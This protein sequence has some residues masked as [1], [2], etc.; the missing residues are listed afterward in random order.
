MSRSSPSRK[1]GGFTLVE[2]LVVIAIVAALIALLLPAV[3]NAREAARR[4]DCQNNLKQLA[5]AAH[6]FESAYGNFPTVGRS[7]VYVG[8]RPTGG[9]NLWV[10]LLPYFE[11]NNLYKKWDYDDNRNNVAGGTTAVTAQVIGILLCPSDMLPEHVVHNTARNVPPWSRGFYGMS[12]YGGNAG[13]RSGILLSP[14]P[15]YGCSRDGIFFLE[16]CVRLA[17]VT[18]GSSNT[19]LFGERY[20][21]DPE[22]ELRQPEVQ[23]GLDSFAHLGKWAHVVVGAGIMANVTLHTAERINYQEPP[24]G[25]LSTWPIRL[26]AFGSG[27]PGGANFAFADGSARFVSER[28]RLP[29]LWALS[30]RSGGEVVSADAY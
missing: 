3:Q 11:Q 7:P 22:L 28:I 10:E 21:R 9:T 26:N 27:H 12:S 30:T 24:G 20:H 1:S 2:L 14:P 16:S 8:D 5:T 29:I 23:F 6:E 15:F 4:V 13:K 17:D 18:D 19:L 25:D